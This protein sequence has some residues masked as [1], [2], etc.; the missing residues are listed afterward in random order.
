MGHPP[1][2]NAYPVKRAFLRKC[3]FMGVQMFF[4]PIVP[5]AG[6]TAVFHVMQSMSQTNQAQ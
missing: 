4:Y 2:E 6:L 1:F 3:R 5:I